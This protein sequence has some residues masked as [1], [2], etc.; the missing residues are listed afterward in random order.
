MEPKLYIPL[1]KKITAAVLSVLL[2]VSVIAGVFV[3]LKRQNNDN[4][5]KILSAVSADTQLSS[6]NP[7]LALYDPDSEVRGIWIATVENINFPSKPGLSANELKAELDDIVAT[8]KAASLNTIYFQVRP[9]ADALYDSAYFPLSSFLVNDQDCGFPGGFDP[10][11]YLIEIAHAQQ[12]NVHAWVNPLRVTSGTANN[13]EHDLSA[14]GGFNPARQNP[15]WVIPYADGKL[16]FDAGIPEVRDLIAAGVGEIVEKYD[17]DGIIFDDYFYP[18]PVSGAVFDDSATYA[19]Y[20]AGYS[21]DDWRRNNVNAMIEQCY[22]SIKAINENCKFGVAPFGVWQSDDGTNGGSDTDAF[23][24]YEKIYCDALAWI[25]GG[26][27]DYISPQI[28]WQFSY[29][30]ARFDVLCRWWNA[31][32]EGTG[33]DLI[34]SH[35]A[36]RSSEWES[37]TE[38]R[39]QI[40][41]ARREL[42]YRGSILYGYE[43]IKNNSEN[44]M[45]QLQ[46]V[47]SE[48]I[49]Y[50][51]PV[52][53]GMQVTVSS[54]SNGS[55]MTVDSTYIIGSSDPAYPLYLDGEPVSRTKQG[56]FSAYVSLSDGENKF[57]FTQNGV[58]T[59]YTLKKGTGSSSSSSSGSSLGSFKFTSAVPT[60]NYVL[61]SGKT[62][63]VSITAPSG[64]KVTASLG[65][66]SVTLKQTTNPPKNNDYMAAKYEGSIVIPN[67]DAGRVVNLGNI[68]Y[69]AVRG[70]ESAEYV[71][72]NVKAIGKGAEIALEVIN[73]DSELKVATDSWY[74]D[75]YTPASVGMREMAVEM[76]N[77]FYKLRMGGYIS[78]DN[79]KLIDTSVS[80]AAWLTS[81]DVLMRN[82]KTELLIYVN[83]NVPANGYMDASGRFIVTVY[84]VATDMK[85]VKLNDNYLFTSAAVEK[86][87]IEN[88]I[89]ICLKLKDTYNFYGYEFY[90]EG[91]YLIASFRNPQR[92]ADD[93]LPLAGKTIIVD[94]GHGGTDVGALSPIVGYSEKDVNLAITLLLSEK[95]RQLGAEVLETRTDDSTV[96]IYSR[97][98]YLKAIEP[99]LCISVH[100][101]SMAYS[102]DITK[103]RGLLGL[104]FSDAGKLL[105]SSISSAASDSLNR[106]ERSPATQRLAMVRN[107][108]F[109]STLVEVGFITCVEE[110]DYIYTTEGIEKAAEGIAQGVLDF[111]AAQEKYLN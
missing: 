62:L 101:N 22:N 27:I 47:Y 75:D 49:I 87:P 86:G 56:F 30:N 40:E 64:S 31:Q 83:E 89:N 61:A 102:T 44:L 72:I 8:A 96:D 33:V 57:V 46:Q 108:K 28:Y 82:D 70:N 11:A 59:V 110:F 51:D 111:Y 2:I 80:S 98:D 24:A 3:V 23:N 68:V 67:V 12:I 54:P 55:T 84:N 63:A 69:K 81:A 48:K 16:Y 104:Y 74:Y 65:D 92:L 97:L 99:D 85:T 6:A 109:P 35:A 71:G 78:Q 42:T 95:L 41:Y 106:F 66:V 93:A 14:L 50:T 36:Y 52:S 90:Y 26:Y 105:T 60:N 29:T 20:G 38:I 4:S 5:L 100:Q 39:N 7:T 53:N 25:K 21:L 9:T 18:Y 45:G 91:G 19:N 13:P 34:V 10:F 79:V 103:I 76:V 15:D 58:D 73:K 32:C 77:G 107:R 94:A 1:Y 37:D 88:S 17:V 43:A